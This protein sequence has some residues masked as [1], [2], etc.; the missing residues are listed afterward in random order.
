MAGEGLTEQ[1]RAL[2][3]HIPGAT[4][5]PPTLRV[6]LGRA[7]TRHKTWRAIAAKLGVSE[8]TLRRWRRGAAKPKPEN[9]AQLREADMASRIR[10]RSRVPAANVLLVWTFDGRQ[11][12]VS[13]RHL[14]LTDKGIQTARQA[15]ARKGP[16]AGVRAFLDAIGDPWY[17]ERLTAWHVATNKAAHQDIDDDLYDVD[18]DAADEADAYGMQVY[19]IAR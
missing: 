2:F 16:E 7:H 1:L 12:R 17:R 9:L 15:W 19:S 3:E 10:V 14:G 8:S 6:M 13:A 5:Q 11:R 4:K 18:A